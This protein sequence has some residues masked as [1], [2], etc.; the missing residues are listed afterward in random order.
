MRTFEITN[1]ITVFDQD[2]I[3]LLDTAFE[4]GIHYWC[5]EVKVCKEPI[6]PYRWMSDVIP[7]GGTLTLVDVDDDT[8]VADEWEL[9][10]ENMIKG[11]QQY[12]QENNYASTEDLI[13]D[14]D[15]NT[16][17]AIVQYALFGKLVFC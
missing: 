4:G 7:A 1:K 16:A 17:D 9:T 10:E 15:A 12:M 6:R 2:M 14:H 5:G 8:D 13:D 3:D 11:I